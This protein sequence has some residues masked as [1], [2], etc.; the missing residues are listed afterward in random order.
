VSVCA[1]YSVKHHT[2][3]LRFLS[4]ASTRCY[5]Q[6][7]H[8]SHASSTIK[9]IPHPHSLPLC[10]LRHCIIA[11]F[12]TSLSAFGSWAFRV[13]T[14]REFFTFSASPCQV[15]ALRFV[16]KW[17]MRAYTLR[18]HA[19]AHNTCVQSIT[20]HAEKQDEFGKIKR[21]MQQRIRS[22]LFAA[23]LMVFRLS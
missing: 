12:P 1:V 3:V 16:C 4:G 2:S 14:I 15:A 18:A 23:S 19:G 8:N 11:Y 10:P 20:E 7:A 13:A 22:T 21:R 6:H 5:A 9:H 17:I